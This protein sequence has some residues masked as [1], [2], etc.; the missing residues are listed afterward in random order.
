MPKKSRSKTKRT[1]KRKQECYFCKNSGVLIDYKNIEVISRFLTSRGKIIGRQ[2]SGICAK[3]Q[4]SLGKAIKRA[5]QASLLAYTE[6][7]ATN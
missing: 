6:I 2:Y 5:R 3:H 4:R 1:Y 7:H